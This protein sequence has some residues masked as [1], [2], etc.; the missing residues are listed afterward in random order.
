MS[1][2]PTRIEA[3]RTERSARVY[4]NASSPQATT[5]ASATRPSNNAASTAISAHRSP[6]GKT[7]MRLSQYATEPVSACT[8]VEAALSR[9]PT[10]V[11]AGAAGRAAAASCSAPY[12]A[13]VMCRTVCTTIAA[14]A[15]GHA[16]GRPIRSAPAASPAYA[17]YSLARSAIVSSQ[18]PNAPKLR[19]YRASCPSTQS[20]T[21]PR[22][23]STAPA[24]M[25]GRDACQNAARR[26]PR[27]APTP[28]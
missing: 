15:S 24:I 20:S 5:P 11:C 16:S 21:K 8:R 27:T 19:V 28:R 18:P 13:S 12:Q 9:A 2:T 22:Y 17:A 3:E 25:A 14:I 4:A 1:S 10:P 7:T 26:P 6:I 23:S